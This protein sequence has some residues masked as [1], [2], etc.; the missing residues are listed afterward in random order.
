[1]NLS[2]PIINIDISY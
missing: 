2:L 1:V